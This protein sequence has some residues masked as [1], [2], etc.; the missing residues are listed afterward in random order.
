MLPKIG[1]L[2]MLF[3]VPAPL[4]DLAI[5]HALWSPSAAESGSGDPC[6]GDF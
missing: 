6:N 2:I 4:L 5:G 1:C 3:A